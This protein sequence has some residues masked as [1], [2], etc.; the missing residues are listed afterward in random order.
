MHVLSHS[1]EDGLASLS[2]MRGITHTFS[3]SFDKRRVQKLFNG[4]SHMKINAAVSEMQRLDHN[5]IARVCTEIVV[6]A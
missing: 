6:K 1:H 5:A 4:V 3:H 2:E